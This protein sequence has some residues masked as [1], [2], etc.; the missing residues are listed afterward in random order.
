M[1]GKGM[2]GRGMGGR[3]MGRQGNGEAGEWGGRS[4]L[5]CLSL[6]PAPR[7]IAFTFSPLRPLRE[8][9]P[10]GLKVNFTSKAAKVGRRGYPNKGQTN[11]LPR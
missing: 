5:V 11:Y 4:A 9:P 6:F 7:V 1:G 3:G 8:E 10:Q 2:G